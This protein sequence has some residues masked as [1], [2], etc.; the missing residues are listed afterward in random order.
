[1]VF[2]TKNLKNSETLSAYLIRYKKVE[3][4]MID[5]VCM[6]DLLSSLSLKCQI[7]LSKAINLKSV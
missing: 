5:D 6:H 1:M 3:K 7:L 2:V 4:V